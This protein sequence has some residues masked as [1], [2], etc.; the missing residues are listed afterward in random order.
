[1]ARVLT[2]EDQIV[3]PGCMGRTMRRFYD[4]F[5]HQ[6]EDG[7]DFI[8]HH[9]GAKYKFLVEDGIVMIEKISGGF[10]RIYLVE[11]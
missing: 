7:A 4:E 2:Q 6:L 5:K 8:R 9:G 3:T 1:M 10:K 11:A